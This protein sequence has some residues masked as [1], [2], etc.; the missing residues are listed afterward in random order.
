MY[1]WWMVGVIRAV[2]NSAVEKWRSSDDVCVWLQRAMMNGVLV[3]FSLFC[4][5]QELTVCFSF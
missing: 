2:R 4:F 3:N 5:Y 1:H